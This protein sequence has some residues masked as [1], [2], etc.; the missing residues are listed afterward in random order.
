MTL[1]F[2]GFKKPSFILKQYQKAHGRKIK[3]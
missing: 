1:F 2:S 3:S